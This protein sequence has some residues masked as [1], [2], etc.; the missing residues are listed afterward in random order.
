MGLGGTAKSNVIG[1]FVWNDLNTNG[2]QNVGEPGISNVFVTLY[3]NNTN[4][5][6]ATLT[7]VNGFYSFTNQPNG[8]YFVG[9]TPPLGFTFTTND[10]LA[11]D[12]LN[13]DVATPSGFTESFVYTGVANTNI[14][15]GLFRW[16]PAISLT[17][18]ASDG[19]ITAPDGTDLY[20][21]NETLVTYTYIV[22][23]TGNTALSALAVFDDVLQEF[24]GL[25]D[26]PAQLQPGESVTFTTSVVI[27]ASVTNLAQVSAVPVDPKTC[28]NLP[29]VD[30][31]NDLDDAVVIVVAP[32]YTLEKTLTSPLGRSAAVGETIQFTITIVNTG[33]VVLAT[34]PVVDT[35]DTAYL[36]YASSIPPS[37]DNVNDGSI[38]WADIGPVPVGA[39]TSIV[40]S[41]TAF[42]S[43]P[44]GATNTV[45]TTP[46]TPPEFPPVPPATNEVPYEITNPGFSIVKTV[47]SPAGRAAAIGESIVFQITVQNT[48][49]V[50]LATIPLVDTYDINFLSYVS[51]VPASDDNTD[52]GTINWADIGT[53]PVGASTSVVATFTALASTDNDETNR[54]VATPTTPPGNPPVPPRTNEVPYDISNPGYTLVKQV[55][56]PTGRAAAV[57]E[58]I[59]FSLTVNNTGD[60]NFVT[61]PLVD[62]FDVTYLT[63]ASAIPPA[64][65]VAGGVV[66]WTDVGPLPV[67]ASTTVF[68][69]VIASASTLSLAETNVVVASPT[70][71]PT[72]PPVP[73]R[74][75]EVPY[76]ISDPQFALNKTIVSPTGRPAV[77]GESIVFALTVTNS[78]DV[79]LTTVPVTDTYDATSISFVSAV[80]AA[81]SSAP[82]V[83]TW[84][85]VGPL[86][87]GEIATIN[88]T[89]TAVLPTSTTGSETN[90]VVASPTTPPDEPPVPPRTNEVPY[91]VDTV[92]FTVTKTLT[93]PT[94]RPALVGETVVFNLVV[95]NTGDVDLATIPLQDLYDTNFLAVISATPAS[96]DT[97]NDGVLNWADVGSLV[98]GA[99]TTVVARFQAVA[100]TVL[101]QQTNV[102]VA[103]PTPPVD[104]PPTLV[105][106]KTNEVPYQIGYLTIGDTVWL[107][108]DGNGQPNENLAVQGINTVRVELY[109]VVAGVTNLVD[110]RNTAT[111]GPQR[112]YYIFTNLPF[113][114]Y[115]VQVNVASLPAAMP[116]NGP[117]AGQIITLVPTTP[118]RY[119]V[120]IPLNG[121]FLT[122]DF[123]F[124]SSD[125]TAVDLIDFR[126]EEI[127]G[128]VSLFW[129]T[130]TEL[131]NMGFNLYRSTAPDGARTKVNA[132]LVPGRGTGIGGSYS[133]TESA[134]LTDGTYYYWLEDVEYDFST[135]EHGPVRLTIGSDASNDILGTAT[136]VVDGLVK[137]TADSFIRSG[138]DIATV[139][140]QALRVLVNGT[141]IAA[142]TTSYGDQFAEY[143][144]VLA[145][146][147]NTELDDVEL[148]VGYATEGDPLRMGMQF[149]F[150]NGDDGDV[151]TD[152][153]TPGSD[154]LRATLDQWYVRSMVTGFI[155]SNIWLLDV[156]NPTQPV[157]LVG[158]D[159]VNVNGYAA[160][161]YSDSGTAERVI[162]AAGASKVTEVST[163]TA[164]AAE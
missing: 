37:D 124:I 148:S 106:P 103:S 101:G 141:E 76:E 105:P 100:P 144:Y 18:L 1:D 125:P 51:S 11:D 149:V 142:L 99:S 122:A 48:G 43:T 86:A 75:N 60:V 55:V 42:A 6:Q 13:S 77:V 66:T 121:S 39:T 112:G 118:L 150:L 40:A 136:M 83:I 127:D 53:L 72:E 5:V 102:V 129:E 88:A 34:V 117:N 15:A 97:V 111:V 120:P 152:A 98:S 137:I 107:D 162:Y 93:S 95:L 134:P 140:P 147:E 164:P 33:D 156:T 58:T 160:L 8:V 14:D 30:P 119:N 126:A 123:G 163:L 131:N 109:N 59:T 115:F 90:T 71:P 82:G 113:G 91:D 145:Y 153:V 20:V 67:G 133:L 46:T 2:I 36:T 4:F 19:V 29:G 50:A 7:D 73:P 21:T 31:V 22:T 87:P 70:T 79:T 62:T 84:N 16:Q 110:F 27:F 41:F 108:L 44:F 3:D 63:Y 116:T 161:Y 17:K 158:A 92:G 96:D 68:L 104:V 155:D 130:S 61:L 65:N 23:N 78:G 157:L 56:S 135:R 25:L 114:A 89:F 45:V 151:W 12:A 132:E 85:N 9:F 28:L 32:G 64:N 49:D 81:N 35:Y 69:N 26:C 94:G 159:I 143:D 138:I 80:P 47:I 139:N 52:D 54:V 24:V 128:L 10:V 146:V 57:G 154:V 38:N 74:T